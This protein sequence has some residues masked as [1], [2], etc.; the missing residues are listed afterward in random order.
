M[1]TSDLQKLLV[2]QEKD[3]KKHKE[4]CNDFFA[5]TSFKEWSKG[6]ST[7]ESL[8]C[9]WHILKQ[10]SRE[11]QT[12]ARHEAET[13]NELIEMKE[14]LEVEIDGIWSFAMKEKVIIAHEAARTARALHNSAGSTWAKTDKENSNPNALLDLSVSVASATLTDAHHRWRISKAMDGLEVPSKMEIKDA[15]DQE[16]DKLIAA[17]SSMDEDDTIT[18]SS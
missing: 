5:A 2:Q 4:I 8:Q 15:R 1:V 14:E 11:A 17:S 13:E 12:L 16:R 18:N 10:S 3:E 9:M 7:E 6:K